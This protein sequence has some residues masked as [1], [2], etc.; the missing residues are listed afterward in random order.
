MLNFLSGLFLATT[1]L[2]GGNLSSLVPQVAGADIE[3]VP[4]T[5]TVEHIFF[6]S[7][8][9]YPEKAKTDLDNI[10]GYKDNM[11]TAFQF[12]ELIQ[13]LY[14]NNFILI[15]SEKLYSFDATGKIKKEI[16]YLP[17]GKKPLII[18]LDDLSY[19]K[20]MSKGGFA[21]K[22]VLDESGAVKT[23]VVT[24]EGNTIVTDDGDVVPIVDKFVAEHPDF[25]QDGAKG[26]IAVTGFQGILGYRTQLNAPS[27]DK[28]ITAVLPIVDALKKSGWVFAN[29]SF[30]H[31]Q[32]YLRN[33]ITADQLTADI[34]KWKDQVGSLVGSTDIFIGP[35]GQVFKE[36]DARRKQLVDSGFTALYGVGMDG[37]L[38]YLGDHFAMNRIDIDGLRL[39]LSPQTLFKKFGIKISNW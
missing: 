3:L 15:N 18:S 9:V 19:Y 31:N 26:I 22:L 4:Y 23:E 29:H 39:R 17:K 1:L 34:T 14:D 25:S 27:R 21:N 33:T 38:K 16:L 35:F 11:I 24:P 12:K 5:G 13:Q 32:W 30:T 2:S 36:G 10:G 37:Y 20:Y 28:E 8:I 7:L 6:H